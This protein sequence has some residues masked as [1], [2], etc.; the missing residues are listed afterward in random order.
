MDLETGALLALTVQGADLGDT[1]TG[2]ETISGAAE[3]A[4]AVA[5]D[6][7]ANK[8]LSPQG[9]QEVVA[10]MGYHSNDVLRDLK[11]LEMRPYIIEPGRGR[12]NWCGKRLEQ[13]AV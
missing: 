12:R 4:A 5:Q 1:A 3:Q 13:Q 7:E 8:Q 2:A 10:G 6:R 9:L 11:A